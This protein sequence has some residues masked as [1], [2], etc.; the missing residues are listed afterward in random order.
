MMK[1]PRGGAQRIRQSSP[2]RRTSLSC[3][4]RWVIRPRIW[5]MRSGREIGAP[6]EGTGLVIIL[7]ESAAIRN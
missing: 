4:L 5:R 6:A 7:G 3:C 1:G 2:N